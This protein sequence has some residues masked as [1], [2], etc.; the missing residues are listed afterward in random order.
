MSLRFY[1]YQTAQSCKNGPM[2]NLSGLWEGQYKYPNSWQAPVSFDVEITDR[3]GVLS[4]II[5]EPNTFD[6]EAGHLLT[7]VMAG[8]TDGDTVTFTKTYVGEGYA[9]HSLTYKGV[10]SDKDTRITGEWKTGLFG[11]KFEMTRLSGGEEVLHKTT[12]HIE[13]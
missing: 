1:L 12:E 6:G 10:L 7:A 5:S 13:I 2:R 9:Q 4:G 8:Q 11:G 3:G